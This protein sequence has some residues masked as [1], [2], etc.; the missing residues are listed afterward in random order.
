MIELFKEL[1]SDCK[2]FIATVLILIIIAYIAINTVT[3]IMIIKE[4]KEN[5]DK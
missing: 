5:A 4:E 1:F 3:I 2:G